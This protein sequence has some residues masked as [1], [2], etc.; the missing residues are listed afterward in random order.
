M[1]LKGNAYDLDAIAA[2]V[3]ENV[4]LVE[5]QRSRGYMLRDSLFPEDIKK[6]SIRSKQ[7][8]LIRF[9]L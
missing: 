4:K 8:I 1:P 2:A 9:V 7:K 6:L 5:I 3:D